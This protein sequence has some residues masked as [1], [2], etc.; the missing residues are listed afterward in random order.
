VL[1]GSPISDLEEAGAAFHI[2][3]RDVGV[4]NFRYGSDQI[5]EIGFT[6][7]EVTW[8]NATSDFSFDFVANQTL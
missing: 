6:A 7:G 3:Y 8:E 1:D 4:N 2:E 5:E